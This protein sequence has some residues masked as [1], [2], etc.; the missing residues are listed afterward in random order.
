MEVMEVNIPYEVR[1]KEIQPSQNNIDNLVTISNNLDALTNVQDKL[2]EYFIMFVNNIL[3]EQNF[4]LI[5]PAEVNLDAVRRVN[6]LRTNIEN[7]LKEANLLF[8]NINFLFFDFE[9][10]SNSFTERSNRLPFRKSDSTL[11]WAEEGYNHDKLIPENFLK[12]YIKKAAI[13]SEEKYYYF[14]NIK[15]IIPVNFTIENLLFKCNFSRIKLKLP[16]KILKE[17]DKVHEKLEEF[18]KVIMAF[19]HYYKLE[20]YNEYHR[21]VFK[22]RQNEFD[23]LVESASVL[24]KKLNIISLQPIFQPIFNFFKSTLDSSEKPYFSPFISNPGKKKLI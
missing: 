3:K 2:D 20:T 12:F 15:S 4:R 18:A 6:I 10:V 21:L 9:S 1:F 5:V 16:V 14:G 22:M 23:A 7:K 8:N 24:E 13:L 11:M 19:W 17:K